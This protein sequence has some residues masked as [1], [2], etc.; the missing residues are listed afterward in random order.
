MEIS[1][2]G[3]ASAE[4]DATQ[5]SQLWTSGRLCLKDSI[6][7]VRREMQLVA[8]DGRPVGQVAAVV[9]D[10]RSGATTHILLCRLRAQPEYR[11]VA[12]PLIAQVSDQS[13]QLGISSQG[14][15][16]L[17]IWGGLVFV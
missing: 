4:R 5:M 14:V 11:L 17:P 16:E 9:M 6:H 13:I 1:T 8:I 15:D 3:A 2:T 10:R 7:T 12:L